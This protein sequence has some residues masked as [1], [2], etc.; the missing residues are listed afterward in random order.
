MIHFLQLYF[1]TVSFN[2]NVLKILS[3]AS[4]HKIK[5]VDSDLQN[6]L[7]LLFTIV[8]YNVKLQIVSKNNT[9]LKNL[10]TGMAPVPASFQQESKQIIWR[11]KNEY[12]FSFEGLFLVQH[13]VA[14][15]AAATAAAAGLK[16]G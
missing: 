13:E 9:N 16:L 2:C 12:F 3:T 4:V 15:A 5:F 6:N 14:A 1:N 7:A 11:E 10:A 8:I